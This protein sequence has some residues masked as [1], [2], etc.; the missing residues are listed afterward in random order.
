MSGTVI[1]RF[2]RPLVIRLIISLFLAGACTYL[3]TNFFLPCEF[4]VLKSITDSDEFNIYHDFDNDG[5]SETM[6]FR[7]RGPTDHF[8]YIRN[9]NGGIIDQTNYLEPVVS[10]AQ[11]LDEQFAEY[12]EIEIADS[13]PG[14]P[15]KEK[16]RIF[17]PYYTTK[18]N[19]TGMGLAIAK[20]IIED[21]HGSIEVHGKSGLGA[22]FR[23]S[24]PVAKEEELNV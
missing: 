13:G 19:G 21:H 12:L 17:E 23:F 3:L 4:I 22:V 8:I 7:N 6:E 2:K 20:K 14:I 15:E 16:N 9:R 24:L 11:Y 18:S 1:N 10:L 5:F